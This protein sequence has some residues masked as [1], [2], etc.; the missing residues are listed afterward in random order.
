MIKKL[1]ATLTAGILCLSLAACGGSDSSTTTTDSNSSGGDSTNNSSMD[2]EVNLQI[3][4]ASADFDTSVPLMTINGTDVEFDVFRYYYLN[5]K[6]QLDYGDSSV[7]DTEAYGQE[8]LDYFKDYVS[9]QVILHYVIPQTFEDLGL[10]LAPEDKQEI[11]NYITDLIAD[12]EEAGYTY[13]QFLAYNYMTEDIFRQVLENDKYYSAIQ[14]HLYGEDGVAAND[15][16]EFVKYVR[17]NYVTCQ[18]ILIAF[19][20]FAEDEAYADATEDELKAA[21][22]ELADEL[23]DRVVTDGDDLYELSQIYGDDPGMENN[24]AGYTFTYGEMVQEFEDKTF[25]LE[26]GAVG[27]PVET[28]YGYHIIKKLELNESEL[29]ANAFA[30][31]LTKKLD[32]LD[33]TYSA[34]FE[35]LKPTSIT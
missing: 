23:Y 35:N 31:Y 7:W 21:A 11:D 18:H 10:T 20:H 28:S 22:K 34:D 13:E 9:D 8:A 32:E 25:E 12:Y 6:Y 15:E 24:E 14:D 29:Y 2:V 5:I 19:E 17:E 3:P 1:M 16:D 33:V 26:V 30:A 4:E 27:E